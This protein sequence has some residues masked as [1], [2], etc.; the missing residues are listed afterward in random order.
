MTS[1]SSANHGSTVVIHAN[2][3]AGLPSP[4][5]SASVVAA[6]KVSF[7]CFALAL[8]LSLFC[9]SVE[10]CFSVICNRLFRLRRRSF[11]RCSFVWWR[12]RRALL[13]RSRSFRATSRAIAA[14]FSALVASSALVFTARSSDERSFFSNSTAIARSVSAGGEFAP[15]RSPWPSSSGDKKTS[16]NAGAAEPLFVGDRSDLFRAPMSSGRRRGASLAGVDVSSRSVGRQR[17]GARD[18]A[19]AR[20]W[21]WA[22]ARRAGRARTAAVVERL[23][24]RF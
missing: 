10:R 5:A 20:S 18:A 11:S 23:V 14:R 17:T 24:Y 21:G 3:S 19:N 9:A 2:D 15:D 22:G 4:T 1:L 12:R 16:S 13:N 6:S 7:C 8:R